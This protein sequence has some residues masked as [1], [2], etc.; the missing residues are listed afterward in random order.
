M[1]ATT[2]GLK[3]QLV[4]GKVRARLG[5]SVSLSLFVHLTSAHFQDSLMIDQKEHWTGSQEMSVFFLLSRSPWAS[6]PPSIQLGG[7]INRSPRTPPLLS[8]AEPPGKLS[9]ACRQA[10]CGL[11]HLSHLVAMNTSGRD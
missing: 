3:P 2:T 5:L 10:T 6:V 4:T 1:E 11:A 7:W 9:K 8:A